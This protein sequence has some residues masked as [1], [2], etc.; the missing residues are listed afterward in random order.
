MMKATVMRDV[1]ISNAQDETKTT[2]PPPPLDTEPVSFV[3]SRDNHHVYE[4]NLAP[5]RPPPQDTGQSQYVLN[6]APSTT[7]LHLILGRK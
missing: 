3:L 6:R 4:P 7:H 5:V 1:P 2:A